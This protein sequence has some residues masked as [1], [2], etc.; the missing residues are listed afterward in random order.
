MKAQDRRARLSGGRTTNYQ[1]P[2]IIYRNYF[3]SQTQMAAEII[4]LNENLTSYRRE[5]LK[6]T[7]QK[8]KEGLL[9]SA[10]SIDEKVFIKT[11]PEGRPLRVYEKTT[12]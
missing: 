5:L 2:G 8:R 12:W 9:V 6:Q 3:P 4:Y 10:W 1:C 11:S 7:N